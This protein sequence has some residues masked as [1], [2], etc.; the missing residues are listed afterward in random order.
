MRFRY[1]AVLGLAAL[2]T[3]SCGGVTDPSKNTVDIWTSTV[4]PGGTTPDMKTFNVSNTGEYSIVITQL[5]PASNVA[6]GV[7]FGQQTSA[8][9]APIQENDFS[10]LN[11]VA[12]TGSIIKGSYC[13]VA[14]D[15]LR[16]LSV[17]ESFTMKIS[18]P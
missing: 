5:S 18:H 11:Q 16:S 1:A 6:L 8:G 7:I 15:A 4:P 9:C 2:L 12:L 17:P 14:F 3:I 10:L 13:V